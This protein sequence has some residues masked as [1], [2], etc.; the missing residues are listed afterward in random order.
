MLGD[1]HFDELSGELTEAGK[2]KIR[3]ILAEAPLQHR[4]IY[5]HRDQA[6]EGTLIRLDNV[7]KLVASMVPEGEL[8]GV[9]ETGI[10]TRGWPASQ[11]DEIGRR[12]DSSMPNPR[13]SGGAE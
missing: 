3:W 8:P 4:D 12:F 10:S 5:V 11:V 7:Q 9:F 2:L 13:L 1:H 6:P